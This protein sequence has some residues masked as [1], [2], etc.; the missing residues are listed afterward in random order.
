MSVVMSRKA[1]VGIVLVVLILIAG[2]AGY[3]YYYLPSTRP[4]VP[5]PGTF[6]W[7]QFGEPDYLDP[8]VDYETAG[9]AVLENVYEGLVGYNGESM[10]DFIPVL[11]ESWTVSP[12]GL[13]YTFKLR[14]GVKFH[15]GSTMA[16]EDVKYSFDRAILIND[17]DGPSWILA[18]SIKGGPKYAFESDTWQVTDQM[19]V[20]EYLA[21]EGV[22][23]I[24]PLTVQITL[25][26]PYSPFISTL[27][28]TGPA[29]IVSK[30]CVEMHGGLTPGFHNEWM[31]QNAQCGTGPYM[32]TEWTAKQ[33]IV[34]QRFEDYWGPKPQMQQAIIQFVEEVGTRELALFAGEADAVSIGAANM[35]DIVDR[36]AW[37][38]EGRL[39]P[40]KPGL[41]VRSEASITIS[42]VLQMNTA[43]KEFANKNFREAMR[44]AFDYDTFIKTVY[45]GFAIRARSAIPTGFIGY[46][47]R[48]PLVPYDTAKAKELFLKAK[49]EGAYTDGQVIQVFYNA[50]NEQR[51]RGLLLLK[52]TID[53]MQVGFS[54]DV[55]A[56]DWPTFLAKIRARELPVFF[57]GWA[58]DYA[59]PDDYAIP[60]YDGRIGTFARRIGYNNEQVNQWIDQAARE[61]DP[62]KRHELYVQMQ[63]AVHE[64]AVYIFTVQP[65]Y[66]Y[67]WRDWVHGWMHNA[68]YASNSGGHVLLKLIT[69]DERTDQVT[70]IIDNMLPP[71]VLMAVL[72]FLTR[73]EGA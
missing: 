44:Y 27:A 65:S 21:A 73:H 61:S 34:L 28:Y 58:P 47:E 19:A 37:L 40:L 36:D 10:K 29:A 59:D 55:Q 54:L 2:V 52:D 23:V 7:Q 49:S 39:A 22:K 48:V 4:L 50:G 6:V 12:D 8:A 69:K 68:A 35:F 25:D 31:D 60:F 9:G 62:A 14:S 13:V 46:D 43:F 17:P 33:R 70:V 18:Q 38:N 71:V 30:A 51:R 53:T 42:P 5:N 64:D 56:L 72:P 32:V 57:V 67:V 24:D 1:T 26:H 11:A 16:A 66:T 15:D 20:Q 41:F 45:N 3:Y 63:L